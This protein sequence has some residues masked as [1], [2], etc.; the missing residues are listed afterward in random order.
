MASQE[1]EISEHTSNRNATIEAIKG[2]GILTLSDKTIPLEPG[3]FA[4]MSANAP[5][6]LKAKSNQAFILTLS[7]NSGVETLTFS[8]ERKRRSN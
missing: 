1:T 2:T 3:V 6:A 5:Y 4:F 7:S 8:D